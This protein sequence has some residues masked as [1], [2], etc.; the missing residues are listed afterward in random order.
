MLLISKCV[1]EAFL[2]NQSLTGI[3][4]EVLFKT[5]QF[6]CSTIIFLWMWPHS[7]WWK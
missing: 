4:Q 2:W 5:I 6:S 7:T 1:T 3:R